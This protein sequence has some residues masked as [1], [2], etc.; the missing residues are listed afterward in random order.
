MHSGFC[1][2]C[3]LSPPIPRE[4]EF[5]YFDLNPAVAAPCEVS[6]PRELQEQAHSSALSLV[7]VGPNAA[8]W[9]PYMSHPCF[10]QKGRN[11]LPLWHCPGAFWRFSV[12]SKDSCSPGSTT[13]YVAVQLSH[14]SLLGLCMWDGHF[15]I[16]NKLLLSPTLHSAAFL[17]ALCSQALQR[18][19]S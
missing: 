2:P 4:A 8:A 18:N 6:L 15:W 16:D 14:W 7:T 12:L 10:V 17:A 13:G 3:Y 9:C 11:S 1:L 5:Q 19:V